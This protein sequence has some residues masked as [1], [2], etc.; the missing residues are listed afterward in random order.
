MPK[1]LVGV[2]GTNLSEKNTYDQIVHSAT[3]AD[4]FTNKGGVIR[5]FKDSPKEI[6]PELTKTQFTHQLS[7]P[8]AALD[9]NRCL[10][11]GRTI[12]ADPQQVIAFAIYSGS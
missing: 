5:L 2:K 6:F 1:G 11:R 3:N 4:R 7:R 9:R 8:F 10:D 12:G